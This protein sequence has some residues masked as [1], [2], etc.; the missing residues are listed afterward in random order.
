[1]CNDVILVVRLDCWVFLVSPGGLLEV[2]LLVRVSPLRGDNELS[3]IGRHL[4]SS[5]RV[6]VEEAMLMMID[7]Q[8]EGQNQS[9]PY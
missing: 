4:L 1:M 3:E 7:Q 5:E 8:G 9:S 6:T 2:D